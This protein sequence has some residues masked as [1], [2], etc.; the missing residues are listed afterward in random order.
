[1]FESRRSLLRLLQPAAILWL[2]WLILDRTRLPHGHFAAEDDALG[3]FSTIR[4]TATENPRHRRCHFRNV[5][6][7][8]TS[9]RV[10]F[11]R[12]LE[13]SQVPLVDTSFSTGM[14]KPF[15]F[16]RAQIPANFSFAVDVTYSPLPESEYEEM[17]EHVGIIYEP[18]WPANFGH[19]LGDDI[20]PFWRLL[21]RF[22]LLDARNGYRLF[23]T[24]IHWYC[25]GTRNEQCR[26]RARSQRSRC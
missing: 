9:G 19:A 2:I 1:M 16:I 25:N 12:P 17:R 15:L 10:S 5:C 6:L 8:R 13:H 14:P 11:Y 24:G 23:I 21:R 4:C 7:N 26:Y 22:K 20:F 18:F 3:R